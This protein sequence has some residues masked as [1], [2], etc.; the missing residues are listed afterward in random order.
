MPCCLAIM[1]GRSGP[2]AGTLRGSHVSWGGDDGGARPSPGYGPGR[3]SLA[4]SAAGLGDSY[5]EDG[6]GT[7][8]HTAAMSTLQVGRRCDLGRGAVGWAVGPGG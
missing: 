7:L 1:R 4:S 8:G 3:G 5:G 6:V 2:G